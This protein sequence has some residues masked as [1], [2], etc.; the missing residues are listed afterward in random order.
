MICETING[1]EDEDRMPWLTVFDLLSLDL[2][3]VSGYEAQKSYV[4]QAVKEFYYFRRAT[5]YN[6]ECFLSCGQ[7][8]GEE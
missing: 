8:I 3:N 1:S 7:V 6:Y 4:S 5:K 2:L